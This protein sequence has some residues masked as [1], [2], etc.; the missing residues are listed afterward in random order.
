[1]TLGYVLASGTL[2][3][4]RTRAG[5]QELVNESWWC[6]VCP[7]GPWWCS[8]AEEAMMTL[9]SQWAR[10]ISCAT[11]G[12]GLLPIHWIPLFVCFWF[13]ILLCSPSSFWTHCVSRLTSVW[14]C[15]QWGVCV[16]ACVRVSFSCCPGIQ[17]ILCCSRL[18]RTYPAEPSQA[19][20]TLEAGA[21]KHTA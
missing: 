14:C 13:S 16:R 3:T 5:T 7:I 15:L 19:L 8:V 2:S 1:M 6:C 17:A 20:V 21:W 4:R 18:A 12:L 11:G 10:T 9:V